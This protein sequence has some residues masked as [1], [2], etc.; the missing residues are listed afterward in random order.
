MPQMSVSPAE[1]PAMPLVM[2]EVS[3]LPDAFAVCSRVGQQA[4][5]QSLMGKQSYLG[6]QHAGISAASEAVSVAR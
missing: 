2:T 4:I 3:E 6:S 5:G 1:S